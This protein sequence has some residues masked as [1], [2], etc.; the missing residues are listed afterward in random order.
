MGFAFGDLL[1]EAK[2]VDVGE[3]EAGGEGCEGCWGKSPTGWEAE[4]V[5]FGAW[6]WGRWSRGL[7]A[8]G[9]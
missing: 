9:W 8:N 3:E 1:E 5:E 2:E 4:F 7:R 6:G